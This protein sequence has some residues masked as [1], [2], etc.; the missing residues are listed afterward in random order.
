M[1]L[2]GGTIVP[3][4]GLA[5]GPVQMIQEN[6]VFYVADTFDF[7]STSVFSINLTLNDSKELFS[8]PTYTDVTLD[9]SLNWL[10]WSGANR[11]KI[12]AWNSLGAPQVYE[13]PTSDPLVSVNAFHTDGSDL[14]YWLWTKG[15]KRLAE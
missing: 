6:G 11:A 3:E 13:P 2:E 4:F 9:A 8:L 5:L 12:T 10:Y 15:L 7:G 14:Y 1:P